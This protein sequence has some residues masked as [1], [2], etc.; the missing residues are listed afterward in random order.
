MDVQEAMREL[1]SQLGISQE[2]LARQLDL[3]LKT[4]SR[5]ETVKPPT[6]K[7]LTKLHD[8]AANA[9]RSDLA[10]V[11]GLAAAEAELGTRFRLPVTTEE[12]Y[13]ERAFQRCVFE[14]PNARAAKTIK[15]LLKPYIDKIHEEDLYALDELQ[16]Q[17]KMQTK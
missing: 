3:T 4:I 1:R 11:F 15:N 10:K 13:L 12:F 5:Y 14:H 2:K 6:G 8:L 17:M 16:R 7:V 9:G